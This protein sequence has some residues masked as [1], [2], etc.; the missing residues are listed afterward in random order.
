MLLAFN[1]RNE[2][3][4]KPHCN[5]VLWLVGFLGQCCQQLGH[6]HLRYG[7]E[8]VGEWL[9]AARKLTVPN[10][11]DKP[12]VDILLE[13]RP[14]ELSPSIR[15]SLVVA[16]L[17][18]VTWDSESCPFLRRLDGPGATGTGQWPGALSDCQPQW[19]ACMVRRINAAVCLPWKLACVSHS[20]PTEESAPAATSTPEP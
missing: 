16:V 15:V 19:E 6:Q 13:R 20:C 12:G 4:S 11:L 7:A 8:S 5:N 2:R 18:W 14:A 3:Q 1:F 9:G 10:L 17:A